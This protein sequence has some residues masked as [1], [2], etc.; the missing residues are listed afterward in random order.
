MTN[1]P[2][3][4]LVKPS[5]GLPTQITQVAVAVPN[6]ATNAASVAVPTNSPA[7]GWKLPTL[8]PQTVFTAILVP[9][10]IGLFILWLTLWLTPRMRVKLRVGVVRSL[11]PQSFNELS[12]LYCERVP[13]HDRVPPIHFRAFFRR[14]HA[15]SSARDF[16]RRAKRNRQPVHLLL[17]AR[18]CH[19]LHGF[20]KAIFVPQVRCVF[21]AYL[22]S[23]RGG[24]HEE[25]TVAQQLVALLVEV[26]RNSGAESVVCEISAKKK[27]DCRAKAKL[28]R[29]YASA[30]GLSLRRIAAKY[31][32]PEICSFDA[33]DCNVT[34][35]EL[36]IA[37][38]ADKAKQ[39]WHT[40]GR[41]EYTDKF[42]A[43]YQNVYLMSYATAEPQLTEKYRDYLHK[44]AKQVFSGIRTANIDLK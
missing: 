28:F 18:T 12:A 8:D 1:A 16:C 9:L 25:R 11:R 44:T 30:H 23:D 14:E 6:L 26:C 22:V 19:G 2:A 38:L 7:Q 3:T 40:M 34:E 13:A 24:T 43:I 5:V 41:Q 32:Q 20:L 42:T 29:D 37:H 36:H 10:L 35:A 17:V 21:I 31:L 15:A 4:N 33:G 27:T 39:A